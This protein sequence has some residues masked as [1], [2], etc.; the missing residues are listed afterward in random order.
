MHPIP[1]N[2]LI[3]EENFIFFFISVSWW[4]KG[5]RL[6]TVVLGFKDTV[7][8][9]KVRHQRRFLDF[10][11]QWSFTCATLSSGPCKILEPEIKKLSTLPPKTGF[12][13]WGIL[14]FYKFGK[15]FVMMMVLFCSKETF[16]ETLLSFYLITKLIF[17]CAGGVRGNN[18]GRPEGPAAEARGAPREPHYQYRYWPLTNI[19]CVT[20]INR[21][22]G[23]YCPLSQS[24]CPIVQV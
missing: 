13:H 2:F 7:V 21:I 17:W 18:R 11:V 12:R 9:A 14:C 6:S 3:Y 5:A 16:E 20:L 24:K 10:G 1:L 15:R 19:D 22:Q 8:A 4:C 23:R